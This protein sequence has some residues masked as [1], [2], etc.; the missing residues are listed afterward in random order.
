MNTHIFRSR[1]LRNRVKNGNIQ[2]LCSQLKHSDQFFS[3]HDL[4][5]LFCPFCDVLISILHFMICSINCNY[6]QSYHYFLNLLGWYFQWSTEMKCL[7]VLLSCARKF[8]YIF[9]HR[10]IRT[11]TFK[12]CF[13]DRFVDLAQLYRVKRRKNVRPLTRTIN[14]DY[15]S[16]PLQCLLDCLIKRG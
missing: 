14:Y 8:L 3:F 9:A 15:R 6:I 16:S 10:W 4:N 11:F 13:Y 12:H 1:T 7:A 5:N 2:V